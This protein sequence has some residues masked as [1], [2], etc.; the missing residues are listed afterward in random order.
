MHPPAGTV[1]YLR[2]VPDTAGDRSREGRRYRR[3]YSFAD[4][5]AELR[6]RGLE[7]EVEDAVFGR[8]V[9]IVPDADVRVMHEPRARLAQVAARGP[10]GELEAAALGLCGL[11]A[12]SAG[13][14]SGA[15]GLTGS[16][17][18]GLQNAASDLDVVVYGDRE[19]RAVHAALHRLMGDPHSP[20]RLP[21]A[22]ELAA[23]AAA[24]RQD[25]PISDEDFLRLQA[26]KV[27]EG[28]FAGRA[29]FARFVRRP[30]EVR[31]SYGDPCY[32]ALGTATLRG[33][34]ADA[35]EAMFTPCRYLVGDV[36]TEDGPAA[37]ESCEI[38]SF[39]GRF[40]DQAR[41]GELVRARGSLERLTWRDGR[42][43]T[44]LTIGGPGDFLVSRPD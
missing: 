39:R 17:L 24:H 36:T 26:R 32:A 33:R 35:S 14:G 7:Y 31:E 30:E 10:Q 3:V 37:G 38:A 22:G 4:Q 9:Q 28:R 18:F 19:C 20:L 12:R 11:L 16:L 25:T 1:A 21:A 8:P 34:V 2:Y 43:T 5:A 6:A 15:I 23:I 13:L 27:N 44:R 40:S 41:G 29:C 42:V